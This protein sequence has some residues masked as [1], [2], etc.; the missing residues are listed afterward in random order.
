MHLKLI[1]GGIGNSKYTCK[2]LHRTIDHGHGGTHYFSEFLIEHTPKLH[3]N[4]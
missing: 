3:L 4:S 1:K 2:V